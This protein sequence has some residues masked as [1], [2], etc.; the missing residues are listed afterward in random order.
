LNWGTSPPR[1]KASAASA[2]RSMARTWLRMNSSETPVKSTV[3]AHLLF[4]PVATTVDLAD[5]ALMDAAV[6]V[7][8]SAPAYL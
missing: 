5:E 4:D 1:P 3:A 8:G 7:S 2:S 6:A